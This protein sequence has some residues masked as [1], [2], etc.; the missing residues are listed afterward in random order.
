MF[1]NSL[2]P[3]T[4]T[5][6]ILGIY[7]NDNQSVYSYLISLPMIVFYFYAFYKNRRYFLD[8]HQ[9]PWM[10]GISKFLRDHAVTLLGF[11]S[12]FTLIFYNFLMRKKIDRLFRKMNNFEANE[13][14]IYKIMTIVVICIS[15]MAVDCFYYFH[16]IP[17]FT[18]IFYLGYNISIYVNFFYIFFVYNILKI[19]RQEFM[20]LNKSFKSLTSKSSFG[21]FQIKTLSSNHFE[22]CSF[23]NIQNKIFAP[24]KLLYLGLSMIFT[25]VYWKAVLS[26]LLEGSECV[27]NNI[28]MIIVSYKWICAFELSWL[29]VARSWQEL[30]NE[31]CRVKGMNMPHLC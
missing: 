22:L 26:C 28:F 30:A 8:S 17:N 2:R 11:S 23:S 16:I 19:S 25:V 10:G 9:F 20:Q 6:Q 5:C 14:L 29:I 1:E 12:L 27:T 21:F 7:F 4:V 15:N 18:F 3:L 13:N 31:V 24:P